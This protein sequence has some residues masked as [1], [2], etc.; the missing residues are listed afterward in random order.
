MAQ[1]S[2]SADTTTRP[3]ALVMGASRGLGLLLAQELAERGHDLA[4]CARDEA[5]LQRARLQLL[6]RAPAAQILV[7]PCDAS[8]GETVEAAV[9]RVETELGPIEVAMHVA[10]IIEVGP[11]QATRREH[12]ERAMDVMAWGPIN[13]ALAVAP[14]MTSRG[15]G[16][17]GIVA[18]IGGKVS[19]PRLLAYSTAKFAAVGFSEGLAAELAGTGVTVT[20]IV[21]GLMRTGSHTAATFYGDAPRQ[22]AWFAPAAS[23][24]VLSMDANKAAHQ[25]V[26]AV[27][28]GRP[29]ALVSPLSHLASR[30]HGVLPGV[31]V[32]AMGLVSRVLPKG[33]QPEVIRGDEARERLGSPLVNRLTTLGDRASRRTNERPD[34]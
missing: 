26:E 22:Y 13:L 29:V 20:A 4:L 7:V 25:M 17:I 24:P 33:D 30:V 9:R 32:R 16:R 21:P 6:S 8:D 28:R 10:G 27:L 11:W 23:L 3:V 1:S 2:P 12:F 14:L 5:S 18:S 34:A 19:P 15:H 31:T